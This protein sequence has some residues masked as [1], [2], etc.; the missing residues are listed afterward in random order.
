MVQRIKKNQATNT[1][2][3]SNILVQFKFYFFRD[4]DDVFINIFPHF[5]IEE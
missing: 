5:E 3:I 4:I 2:K 1:R